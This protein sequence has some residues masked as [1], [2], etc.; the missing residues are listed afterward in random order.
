MALPF[1]SLS[2][3]MSPELWLLFSICFHPSMYG[4]RQRNVDFDRWMQAQ[5]IFIYHTED[6]YVCIYWNT[7]THSCSLPVRFPNL[8]H[9]VFY[10]YF[11]FDVSIFFLH[12][13]LLLVKLH[14]FWHTYIEAIWIR[15]AFFYL[16]FMLQSTL[17]A[18]QYFS[19]LPAHT[20]AVLLDMFFFLLLYLE[21]GALYSS[22]PRYKA[23][24][25]FSDFFFS[26][27]FFFFSHPSRFSFT[28]ILLLVYVSYVCVDAF[29]YLPV[30][31]LRECIANV[32]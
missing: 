12:G 25:S 20:F 27:V 6:V 32:M 15:S 2:H 7:H 28:I 10:F 9:L 19:F 13:V 24:H 5:R 17:S 21:F 22:M 23:I 18:L 30:C 16:L 31:L 1:L 4:F 14:S 26:I 11:C 29:F 8:I 3:L